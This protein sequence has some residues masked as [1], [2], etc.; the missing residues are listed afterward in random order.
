VKQGIV[1]KKGI[2]GK[3]YDICPECWNPLAQKLNGKGRPINR[4][5]LVATA[6]SHQR[7]GR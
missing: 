1:Y 3:E 4:N 5:R 7:T 2:E 6:E